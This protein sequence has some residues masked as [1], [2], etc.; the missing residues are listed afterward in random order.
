MIPAAAAGMYD[1]RVVGRCQDEVGMTNRE[2]GAPFVN[3]K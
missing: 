1:T 3:C 2:S